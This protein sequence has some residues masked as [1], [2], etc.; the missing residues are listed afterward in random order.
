MKKRIFLACP[1]GIEASNERKQSDGL[2]YVLTNSLTQL[3]QSDGYELIRAD[4]IPESGRISRQILEELRDADL[5][6]ADL[7]GLNANVFYEVGIRQAMLKPLVL[8][9]AKGQKIPF[10]LADHRILF[11]ELIADQLSKVTEDLKKQI[12][13]TL[14]KGVGMFDQDIFGHNSKTP[15]NTAQV[16]DQ[17]LDSLANIISSQRTIGD[18]ISDVGS[19]MR[20]MVGELAG[21]LPQRAGSYVFIEGERP[22]FAALIAAT[23]R[24]KSHVRSTRFFSKSILPTQRAYSKAIRERVTGHDGGPALTHYSRIIAANNADKLK[25]IE[26]YLT[27]LAGFPFTLYLTR[28]SNSFELVVIDDSEVFLHFYEKM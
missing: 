4:G 25:D 14:K 7:T 17:L 21:L 9:A 11:Y 8:V 22:A 27:Q 5:V 6:I 13:S 18:S 26:E 12:D 20:F 23:A 10:D 3:F 2:H 24:A 16:N 1:I 15:R 28:E 19:N